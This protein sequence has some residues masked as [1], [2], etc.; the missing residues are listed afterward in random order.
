MPDRPANDHVDALLRQAVF[1]LADT[2]EPVPEFDDLGS[3]VVTPLEQRNDDMKPGKWIIATA[4]AIV[5]VIAIGAA[6]LAQGNDDDVT[7]AGGGEITIESRATEMRGDLASGGFT[8]SEGI[9]VLGCSS[10]TFVDDAAT[11]PDDDPVGNRPT[12]TRVFTCETGPNQGTFTLDWSYAEGPPTD[13]VFAWSVVDGTGDYRSLEGDGEMTIDFTPG[14]EH[15][16]F[17]GTIEL[18]P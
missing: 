15:E 2:A 5:A 18:R 9:D 16:N 4:A 14:S 10:G 13:P 17:T 8:V 11:Y 12:V 7:A 6:V 3:T 1:E